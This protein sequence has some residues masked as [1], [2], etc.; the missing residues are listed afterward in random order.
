MGEREGLR[1][2]SFCGGGGLGVGVRR[3]FFLVSD[4]F[5]GCGESEGVW[6]PFL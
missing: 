5:L 1:G 2:C 4:F 3:L 6:G